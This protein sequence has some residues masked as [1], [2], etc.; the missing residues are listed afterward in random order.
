MPANARKTGNRRAARA[1]QHTQKCALQRQ[2]IAG[3][4]MQDRTEPHARFMIISAHSDANGTLPNGGQEVLII[5]NF[6]DMLRQV[7][8]L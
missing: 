2:R 1:I 3:V 5:E 6:R 8:T 4:W 7:E